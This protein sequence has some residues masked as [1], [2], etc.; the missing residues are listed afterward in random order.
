MVAKLIIIMV[1]LELR[2]DVGIVSKRMSSVPQLNITYEEGKPEKVCVFADPAKK[3]RSLTLEAT[4]G[5]HRNVF[6]Q[7]ATAQSH[8]RQ[9][10]Y[11]F[12]RSLK[13]H[14]D[15]VASGLLFGNAFVASIDEYSKEYAK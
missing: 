1:E 2:N 11:N 13:M 6:A 3:Y 10:D 14:E 9:G 4:V 12:A 15:A 7:H 5:I 8:S